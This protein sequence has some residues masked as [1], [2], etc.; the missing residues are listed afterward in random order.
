MTSPPQLVLLYH[1]TN[2]KIKRKGQKVH[3]EL[4]AKSLDI[5]NCGTPILTKITTQSVKKKKSMFK[6]RSLIR[7]MLLELFIQYFCA[8]LDQRNN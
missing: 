5:F 6:T 7:E 3:F 8:G 2:I 4:K 1:Y